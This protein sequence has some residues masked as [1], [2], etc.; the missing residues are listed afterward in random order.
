MSD[1]DKAAWL[2]DAIYR[3]IILADA[4]AVFAM[5][6][7]GLGIGGAASIIGS[8][9]GG[10]SRNPLT[11]VYVFGFLAIGAVLAL[12]AILFACATVLPRRYIRKFHD[13]TGQ[14]RVRDL[15]WTF[16]CNLGNSRADGGSQLIDTM[17]KALKLD[18]DITG[19]VDKA[20]LAEIGRLS[21]VRRRKY[22]WAGLSIVLSTMGLAM[23][24]VGITIA[25][26]IASADGEGIFL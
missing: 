2:N 15:W 1:L 23:L 12:V 26:A 11:N 8:L 17:Y 9:N 22:W 18:E 3:D 4:K 21:E 25:V 16:R 20:W 7:A 5:S 24:L 14:G 6:I 10:A 19:A 13:S